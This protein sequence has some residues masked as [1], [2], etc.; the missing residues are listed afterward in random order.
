MRWPFAFRRPTKATADADLLPPSEQEVVHA[1]DE[2]TR[3]EQ[4]VERFGFLPDEMKRAAK[5]TALNRFLEILF[6]HLRR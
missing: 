4:L 3:K 5:D 2:F 6:S 1:G